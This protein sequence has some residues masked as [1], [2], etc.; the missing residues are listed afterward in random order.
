MTNIQLTQELVKFHFDYKDGVLYWKNKT[1]PASRIIIGNIAGA[2]LSNGPD[3]RW[4]IKIFDKLMIR[5][6]LIFLYHHGYIPEIVDHKNR[7]ILDDRIENLRAANKSQNNMNSS[8]RRGSSSIY[9]GVSY[10]KV[11][12]LWRARIFTSN[13][14]KHLGR[15][16]NE[17]DAALAYNKAALLYHKEFANLNVIQ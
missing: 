12:K 6:R 17:V 13:K 7:N 3:L 11:K 10:D 16:V 15:F 1:A 4:K 8:S 5:S 2:L 14:N 9:L